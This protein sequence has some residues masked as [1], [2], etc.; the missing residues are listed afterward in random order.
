VNQE[1]EVWLPIKGYEGLYEVSD[2]GRVK[3]LKRTASHWRGGVRTVKEKIL[4][5]EI[6][7]GD[8]R[9]V[10]LLKD[11]IKKRISVHRLVAFNFLEEDKDRLFVNHIDRNTSNNKVENL[12]WVSRSENQTHACLNANN[13]H[14]GI[15]KTKNKEEYQV[16]FNHNSVRVYLGTFKNIKKALK[17]RDKFIKE[18]QIINKYIH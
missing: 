2:L 7:I 9:R 10:C 6:V 13:N 15:H 5:Q 16:R 17:I 3:S 18:N 8:Y 11:K 12:E 1:K 4:K 14:Y